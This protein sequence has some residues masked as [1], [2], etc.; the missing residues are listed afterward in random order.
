MS[1]I[2]CGDRKI[3]VVHVGLKVGDGNFTLKQVGWRLKYDGYDISLKF[4]TPSEMSYNKQFLKGAVDCCKTKWF[5]TRPKTLKCE[6]DTGYDAPGAITKFE[7][8]PSHLILSMR[9][10]STRFT[11]AIDN[12]GDWFI[13]QFI[14]PWSTCENMEET[15]EILLYCMRAK[16]STHLGYHYNSTNIFE[17]TLNHD[18]GTIYSFDSLVSTCTRSI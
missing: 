2:S 17:E 11:D 8:T 4:A 15:E 7:I 14:F 12:T 3:V 10:T 18:A 16:S 6:I 1:Q 5:T 13:Q 9:S